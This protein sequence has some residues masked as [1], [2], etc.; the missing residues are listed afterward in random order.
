MPQIWKTALSAYCICCAFD[1][2]CTWTA[3]LYVPMN[4]L[5]HCSHGS[6]VFS[7]AYTQNETNRFKAEDGGS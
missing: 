3:R 6:L 5:F 1:V 2:K 7:D 4:T